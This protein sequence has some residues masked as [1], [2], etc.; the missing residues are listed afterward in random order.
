MIS[1]DY[2]KKN[3]LWFVK[4]IL[5]KYFLILENTYLKYFIRLN[6]KN[7]NSLRGSNGKKI[8]KPSKKINFNLHFK[9]MLLNVTLYKVK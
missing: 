7:I 1:R 8:V 9:S 6:S 5:C 3:Y 4:I 2:L